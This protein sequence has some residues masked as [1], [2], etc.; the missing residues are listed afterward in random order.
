MILSGAGDLDGFCLCLKLKFKISLKSVLSK[1]D[2]L[3]SAVGGVDDD[4]RHYQLGMVSSS[5]IGT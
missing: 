3:S 1:M 2:G 4:Y 5:M